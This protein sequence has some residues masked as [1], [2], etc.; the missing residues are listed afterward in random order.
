MP[1]ALALILEV[2]FQWAH[3]PARIPLYIFSSSNRGKNY[4]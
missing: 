2:G 3:I 4:G 1:G